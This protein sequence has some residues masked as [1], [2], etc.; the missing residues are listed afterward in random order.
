MVIK[1][2]NSSYGHCWVEED[3]T[4]YYV[5]VMNGKSKYG[6]Y[7]SLSDALTEYSK[8]CP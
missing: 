1:S 2:G 6:P 8:W 5:Y 3:G 4:L 7:T